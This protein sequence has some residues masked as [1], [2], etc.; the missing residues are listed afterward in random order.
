MVRIVFFQSNNVEAE[1]LEGVNTGFG[2]SANTYTNKTEKLQQNLIKYLNCGIIPGP[3]A[4]DL[5]PIDA[6]LRDGTNADRSDFQWLRQASFD[7]EPITSYTMHESWV[8]ATLLVRSNSLSGGNSG[9]RS[10]LVSGLVHLLNN[11]ISPIIP[12]R[13]SISASGDLIPLSYIAATLQG[14][15]H[16]EV[17][18]RDEDRSTCRKRTVACAALTSSSLEAI[19]LG[20]KEGLA[21]VNGTSVSAAVGCLALQDAHNVITLS[22]VLTAMGVEA[23]RGS[24]ESFHPFFSTIRP[25]VGQ[26][27][28][29]NNIRIFLAGSR[30]VSNK[31]EEYANGDSLRQDR[32]SIRTAP[33]WLGPQLE[34][35]VLADQQIS[36]EINSTTDNPILDPGSGEILHG[37]NF[38]AM[39]VT[40]AMEKTR[41]VIQSIG[42]LL[43]AQCTELMNPVFSNGLPPNLSAD[44]PSESFFLKGV[45]ISVAA[46][47]S[48]LSLISTSVVSHVQNAEMGNQSVNSLAFLSARYTHTA[49]NI[50]SQMSAAYLFALCQALDLRAIQLRF[51]SALKPGLEKTTFELFGPLLTD[52]DGLNQTLWLQLRKAYDTSTAVDSSQRFVQAMKTLRPTII[53]HAVASGNNDPALMPNLI[54]WTDCSAALALKVFE[55]T[56]SDYAINPDASEFLGS[57]SKRMYQFVRFQLGIPFHIE[58]RETERTDSMNGSS[59]RSLGAMLS[60]VHGAI[61]NGTLFIPVMECLREAQQLL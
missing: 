5:E 21:I 14:S 30:L 53:D 44:E 42:R 29:A 61:Q 48:E 51:L 19:Q 49:L 34:D 41:N 18:S 12:I 57:A 16:V 45:D 2:G 40:S 6:R 17:W 47:Q 20:P 4:N 26:S 56:K 27:E 59:D 1:N 37:G 46:L 33:Q 35:L 52:I 7:E 36:I 31:A 32:Y 28:V 39:T 43:F 55:S 60:V 8:K 9:V 22:Q 38:Q 13:G 54:K 50:V 24:N 25:H 10:N 23:L 58:T 15:R 11:N 3:L